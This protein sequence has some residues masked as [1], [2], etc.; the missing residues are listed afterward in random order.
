MSGPAARWGFTLAEVLITLGIIGVVAA[1]TLPTL[2]ADHREKQTVVR[3]KH[4]YSLISQAVRMMIF[5]HGELNLWSDDSKEFFEQ[6]LTKQLKIIGE[7]DCPYAIWRKGLC[8]FAVNSNHKYVLNNGVV[9][10]VTGR[11]LNSPPDASSFHRCNTSV[12]KALSGDGIGM[13]YGG[14][15]FISVDINGRSKPNQYGKDS[16]AF[17]VYTDGVLPQG[18]IE[19]CSQ[20][21]FNMCTSDGGANC[22]AW[23]I[24][25]ENMD[26]LKCRDKLSYDKGPYSCK[27]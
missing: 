3:L 21:G 10:G 20:E 7:Q 4:T 6:E 25:H 11:N 24:Y 5:E 12:Q 14:C 16:F 27:K 18:H 19:Q 9:V 26:Y 17:R 8:S 13:H 2:I 23:V 15:A 22:T 1:V